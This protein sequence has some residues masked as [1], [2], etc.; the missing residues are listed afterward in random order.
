MPVTADPAREVQ[1]RRALRIARWVILGGVLL[2]LVVSGTILLSSE[3]AYHWNFG[4]HLDLGYLD[5]PPMMAWMSAL[6]TSLFGRSEW[7][8]RL[9][10]VLFGGF[11]AWLLFDA[12]RRLFSARAAFYALLVWETMPVSA[13][14]SVSLMPDNP[15]IFGWILALWGLSIAFRGERRALGWLVAGAGLG[16]ALLGKYTAGLLAP[17]VFLFLLLSREHRRRLLTPWPWLALL[18]AAAVFSP[19][20]I[21][22]AQHDWASFRFQFARR[23]SAFETLSLFSLVRFIGHQALAA[24]PWF[25]PSFLLASWWG[26]RGAVAGDGRK[27]F[28]CCLAFPTLLA[29]AYSAARGASHFVWT[30]PAYAAMAALAGA[31][32]DERIAPAA[33][34]PGATKRLT[35]IAVGL[36]AAGLLL[37]W[38]H[39]AWTLPLVRPLLEL[40]GWPELARAAEDERKRLGNEAGEAFL[41]GLG[42]RFTVESALAFYTGRT[43]LCHGKNLI[44]RDGLQYRYW[45]KAGDLRGRNAVVVMEGDAE[46]GL[47]WGGDK[48]MIGPW[49]E[50]YEDGP[51]INTNAGRAGSR[52]FYLVRAR[53]YRGAP[54]KTQRD[55]HRND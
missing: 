15:L 13:L 23:V 49:F 2:R 21:W 43:D 53:G 29:F 24:S 26:V 50:S 20:V 16:C 38:A 12:A 22:N 44:G 33:R 10:P 54:E 30:F 18:L 7:A 45:V 6:T 37:A 55:E 4:Q 3:E 52:P 8:V 9:G 35:G 36:T 39:A 5:H 25:V 28:L 42:R 51:V 31:W 19:V 11:A 1:E 32:T 34:R 41:L 17:S 27:L 47:R 48:K 14:I 46:G 40:R